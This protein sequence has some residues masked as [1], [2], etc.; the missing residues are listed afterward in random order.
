[1]AMLFA[2]ALLIPYYEKFGYMQKNRY[3]PKLSLK[4]DKLPPFVCMDLRPI[5]FS[6][7]IDILSKL[8]AQHY[9]KLNGAIVRENRAVLR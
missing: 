5:E 4:K 2:S 9:T 6:K 1:M 8:Y 3:L 7:D